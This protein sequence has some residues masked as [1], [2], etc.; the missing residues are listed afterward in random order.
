[1]TNETG[2]YQP[3]HVYERSRTS[4]TSFGG[5]RK[6]NR[7]LRPD[8]EDPCLGRNDQA[9]LE[10]PALARTSKHSSSLPATGPS[11]AALTAPPRCHLLKTNE[12]ARPGNASLQ[13]GIVRY[14]LCTS[15][16]RPFI[17][18]ARLIDR[19][20]PCTRNLSRGRPLSRPVADNDHTS[21]RSICDLRSNRLWWFG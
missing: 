7:K 19:H 3:Y 10:S 18:F 1:M 13:E 11:P 8:R 12:R 15:G 9:R 4:R 20:A 2:Y 21:S 16:R 17:P 5:R 14:G 6:G